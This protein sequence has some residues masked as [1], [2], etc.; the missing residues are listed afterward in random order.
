[1][2]YGRGGDRDPSI[3]EHPSVIEQEPKCPSIDLA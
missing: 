1:M 3:I 2:V